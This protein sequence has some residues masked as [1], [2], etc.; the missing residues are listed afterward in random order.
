MDITIFQVKPELIK[1]V[2]ISQQLTVEQVFQFLLKQ[3]MGTTQEYRF[4]YPPS[5]SDVT[6]LEQSALQKLIGIRRIT[7]KDPTDP[8]VLRLYVFALQYGQ[9]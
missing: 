3:E 5:V 9:G 6:D 8:Y 7:S 4:V 2:D 1:G